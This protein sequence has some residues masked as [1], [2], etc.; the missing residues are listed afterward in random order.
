MGAVVVSDTSDL[1]KRSLEVC[2]RRYVRR[3]RHEEVRGRS[4]TFRYVRT[5]V[6]GRR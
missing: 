1:L 2:R 3:L 4:G 5:Q 6:A